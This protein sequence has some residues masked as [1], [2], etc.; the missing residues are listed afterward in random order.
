M[1]GIMAMEGNGPMSGDPKKMNVLLFSN[2]PIALDATVCRLVDLKPEYSY[3]VALGMQA[4]MGTWLEEEIKLLGDPIGEFI[5]RDFNIVR[6]PV[7]NV[8]GK[9]GRIPHG[10]QESARPVIDLAKC[11]RCGVCVDIC[12]IVPKALSWGSAGEGGGKAPEYDYGRC[13]RCFCCQEFCPHGA[14][15]ILYG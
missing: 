10:K 12:P 8:S 1:D 13:I 3:T 4:G 2:D 5:S 6:E 14:I 11:K 7:S 15:G 9:D